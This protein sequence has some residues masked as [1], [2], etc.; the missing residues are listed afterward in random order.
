MNKRRQP[1]KHQASFKSLLSHLME[2]LAP[3]INQKKRSCQLGYF[4]EISD[5]GSAEKI[6]QKQKKKIIHDQPSISERG[7]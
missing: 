4:G 3:N 1:K 5:P 7:K 2:S 6:I